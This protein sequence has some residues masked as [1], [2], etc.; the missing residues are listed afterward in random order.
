MECTV[1]GFGGRKAADILTPR[2]DGKYL[3]DLHLANVLTL[4]GAGVPENQIAV[5]DLC[6]C[7]RSDLLWSHRATHGQ[8]GEMAGFLELSS[9]DGESSD[10]PDG[11]IT[12]CFRDA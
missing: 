9:V 1:T 11:C 3:V 8:R 5:T 12:T 4:T 7:C 2:P 10:R 6:T